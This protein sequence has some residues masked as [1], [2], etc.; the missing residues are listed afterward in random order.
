MV[1]PSTLVFELGYHVKEAVGAW[2]TPIAQEARVRDFIMWCRKDSDDIDARL[3]QIHLV[4]VRNERAHGAP[5]ITKAEHVA[6]MQL[7]SSVVGHFRGG[8][9]PGSVGDMNQVALF[10]NAV[11]TAYIHGQG[12]Q[13]IHVLGQWNVYMRTTLPRASLIRRSFRGLGYVGV[14]IAA[15]YMT[16]VAVLMKTDLGSYT[17]LMS[18]GRG[19]V[20]SRFQGMYNR[21]MTYATHGFLRHRQPFQ[22]TQMGHGYTLSNW[23]PSHPTSVWGDFS[24]N[25]IIS[26]CSVVGLQTM[27]RGGSLLP[28]VVALVRMT[29]TSLNGWVLLAFCTM[30]RLGLLR[31]AARTVRSQFSVATRLSL[32]GAQTVVQRSLPHI[33]FTNMYRQQRQ[34]QRY[35]RHISRM[36]PV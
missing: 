29:V 9:L 10:R 23:H 31:V 5:Q 18:A 24:T 32:G 14:A 25:V 11:A 30:I 2:Y 16:W 17:W 3:R 19:R 6:I 8:W 13:A 28:L 7:I 22:F 15:T 36:E 4:N 21:G 34:L 12:A 35:N 26:A 1:D 27:R 20:P 33:P